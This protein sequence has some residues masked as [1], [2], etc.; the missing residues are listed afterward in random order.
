MK[1]NNLSYLLIGLLIIWS[2]VLTIVTINNYNNKNTQIVNEYEV[3]GFATDFTKIVDDNNT[4]IVSINSNG[5]ISTGFVYKQEGEKVYILTSYHGLN[6]GPIN[7]S[8]GNL[9]STYASIVGRDIYTDLAVLS[10]DSQY[11]VKSLSLADSGALK[12]GEFVISIGTPNSLEYSGSVELG[13]ISA[14]TRVIENSITIDNV[15]SNYYLDVIQLSTN[16]KHG[17]SGSPVLNMNGEVVGMTTM[18]LDSNINFAITS[19]EIKIVADSI[20]ANSNCVKYHTG[21]KGKFI[22]DMPTYIK[23]NLNLAIDLLDGLYVEKVLNDSLAAL[24]GIQTGDVIVSINGV[25]MNNLNNYL[26]VLYTKADLL[27]IK[28]LRGDNTISLTVHI[29]D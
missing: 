1:K 8:F 9:F 11:S 16:L 12:S 2:I 19:N 27:E 4:S 14:D 24:A 18:S 10:I 25:D 21:I 6:N 26:N 28:V 17:Y 13:M 3:N 20:I 29:N 23:S 22:S 5:T 7:V 15:T